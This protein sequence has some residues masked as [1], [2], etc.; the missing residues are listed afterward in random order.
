MQEGRLFGRT[1]SHFDWDTRKVTKLY[2]VEKV[3]THSRMNDAKCDPAGRFWT[4]TWNSKPLFHRCYMYQCLR[5]EG[6]KSQT[7]D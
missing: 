1:V 3:G 6:P 2:E 7:T 4:G 5:D